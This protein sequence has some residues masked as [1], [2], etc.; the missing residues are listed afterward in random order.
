MKGERGATL[1]EVLIALSITGLVAAAVTQ[2]SGF[3]LRVVERGQSA[4]SASASAFGDERRLRDALT[5]LSPVESAFAGD[6]DGFAWAGIGRDEEAAR[7]RLSL[8]GRL[9]ACPA[10]RCGPP[11]EWLS[12]PL[13]QVAYAGPDGIFADEWRGGAAPDLIRIST[14]FGDIV[15]APRVRGAR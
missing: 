14:S 15:I 3:G 12:A 7:W 9:A 10:S 1:L 2:M 6:A 8:D 11:N 13:R 5:A 4:S